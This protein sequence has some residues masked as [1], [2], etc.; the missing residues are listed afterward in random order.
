MFITYDIYLFDTDDEII[1]YNANEYSCWQTPFPLTFGE[2]N[3]YYLDTKKYLS[4]EIIKRKITGNKNNIRK[5]KKDYY[6]GKIK[7]HL[8][9]MKNI[10][11]IH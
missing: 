11:M 7:Y 1:Y 3:I 5:I 6:Y 10:E 4:K 2:K 8:K 9:D